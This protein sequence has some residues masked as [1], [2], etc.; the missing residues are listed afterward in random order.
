M[1]V[2]AAFA[3]P[4]AHAGD[5]GD[6]DLSDGVGDSV[7][8]KEARDLVSGWIA[9]E[10]ETSIEFG[11]KIAALDPFTPYA[12]ISSL[13]VVNYEF[14]F[15]VSVDGSSSN[16]VARAVVPIHGPAAATASYA[17]YDVTYNSQGQVTETTEAATI[18]GSYNYQASEIGFVV[19]KPYIGEPGRDDYISGI[20]ARIT[21]ASQ[22]NAED[23]VTEDTMASHLSPGRSFTFSGGVTFYKIDLVGNVTEGNATNLD[24]I[25]FELQ[26][27][28]DETSDETAEVT[29]NATTQLPTNWTMRTDYTK[30][31]VA[32]GATVTALVTIT[33][34]VN[35]SATTRKITLLGEWRDPDN[36]RKTTNTLQLSITVPDTG[37]GGGGGGGGDGGPTGG[38]SDLEQFLPVIVV[39]G[40]AGALFG[41]L[42][43][44]VLPRRRKKRARERVE[45]LSKMAKRPRSGPRPVP[46]AAAPRPGRGPVPGP[47]PGPR[48]GRIQPPPPPPPGR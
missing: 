37:G 5:I 14:F 16:F 32:P 19:D 47:V 15:D 10:T 8:N 39:V 33:P 35:A 29:L 36:A 24:P 11:L 17:L 1:V 41:S 13:P 20:W 7:S 45:R 28:S 26:I 38:P 6:P 2:M 25:T 30:Y 48:R 27:I 12:D 22:R 44:V 3:L 46:Q 42:Y 23:P 4:P 43:F 18:V 31:S 34:D 40:V 21:S 9:N